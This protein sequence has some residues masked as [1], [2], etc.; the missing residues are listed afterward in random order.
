MMEQ[1]VQLVLQAGALGLLTYLIWWVTQTGAPQLFVCLTGIKSA[2]E[3]HSA[4]IER[5]ENEVKELRHEV[6]ASRGA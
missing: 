6:E 2:L 1:V 4:R 5:L 3:G